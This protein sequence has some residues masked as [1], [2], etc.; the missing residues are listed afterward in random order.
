M[1][2][3]D[4]TVARSIAFFGDEG[5]RRLRETTVAVVGI[6]GLGTLVV[7][8]LAL[9]RVGKLIVIDAEDID[10]TNRN[11]YV[12]VLDDDPIPGTPKVEVARRLVV[13]ISPGT[14]VVTIQKSVVSDE[15]FDALEG[16]SHLFGCVDND[17][18]RVILTE[19]AAAFRIP[20]ID[21][22][23]EIISGDDRLRYGGRV[24]VAW[25]GHGCLSCFD[26]LDHANVRKHLTSETGR[27]DEEAIYG[28]AR[29]ALGGSG[30][31]VGCINGVVASLAVTEFMLAVTGIRPA[32]RLLRYRA[33]LAVVTR[34]TD[35]PP[36]DCYYCAALRGQGNAA[37]VVLSVRQGFRVS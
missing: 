31:S 11:R 21:A 18:V 13:G 36:A 24:V 19:F 27:R 4:P 22:A 20:Y 28:A 2:N 9:L 6:G 12:G 29:S 25:D 35:P 26:E 16:A 3:I 5:Y 1:T 10:T 30:P 7:Q 37:P 23:T 14:E 33:D 15:A 34:S 17:A 8:Q 32:N